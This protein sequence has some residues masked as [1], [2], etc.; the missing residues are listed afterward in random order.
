MPKI[1][2]GLRVNNINYDI[3]NTN[4][5][6]NLQYR[7]FLEE[8]NNYVCFI[9]SV[10]VIYK[11]YFKEMI[12]SYYDLGCNHLGDAIDGS[13]KKFEVKNCIITGDLSNKNIVCLKGAEVE[14]TLQEL[15]PNTKPHALIPKDTINLLI[16]NKEIEG[17]TVSANIENDT[18]PN[19]LTIRGK[20]TFFNL[21]K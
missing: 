3:K 9:N 12:Y 5:T 21:N 8:P 10:V 1:R 16:N 11:D 14:K 7:F 2:K 19:T 17:F 15:N 20:P 18:Y 13:P 4:S 6:N